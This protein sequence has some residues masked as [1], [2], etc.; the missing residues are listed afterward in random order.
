VFKLA[1]GYNDI[2]SIIHNLYG[3][4]PMSL[5][6]AFL[7]IAIDPDPIETYMPN[8][9]QAWAKS[10]IDP[11]KRTL[12][13]ECDSQTVIRVFDTQTKKHVYDPPQT[14]GWDGKACTNGCRPTARLRVVLPALVNEVSVIGY[15][16]MTLHG[17]DS[18]RTMLSAFHQLGDRIGTSIL[19]VSREPKTMTFTDPKDGKVKERQFHPITR[20]VLIGHYDGL[21]LGAGASEHQLPTP[22]TETR[23]NTSSHDDLPKSLTTPTETA[24]KPT[25]DELTIRYLHEQGYTDIT[26]NH[27]LDVLGYNSWYELYSTWDGKCTPI[28][29]GDRFLQEAGL[30]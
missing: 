27:V 23:V 3:E 25:L 26:S 30:R 8:S 2:S 21:V 19:R 20:V 15:F 22:R 4:K 29:V 18:I 6:M 13:V 7:P 16:E 10:K 9:M 17:L 5:D 1:D 11:D 12:M 14:C 24:N 28:T